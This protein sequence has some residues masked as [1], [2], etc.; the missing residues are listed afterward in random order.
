[1]LKTRLYAT[2]AAAVV[3]LATT[4]VAQTASHATSSDLRHQYRFP[5]QVWD[6]DIERARLAQPQTN[7]FQGRL[8]VEYRD[9]TRF[10]ADEMRDWTD[11]DYFAEKTLEAAAGKRIPPEPVGDWEIENAGQRRDLSQA[12]SRLLS[13]L[14]DG[15]AVKAPGDAAVAQVSYDCWIEQQEE[16]WQ[17]DHIQA[18]RQQFEAA[19]ERVDLAMRPAPQPTAA[20]PKPEPKTRV[21][22]RP[23]SDFITLYFDFD[24]ADIRPDAQREIDRFVESIDDKDETEVIVVGH[25]DRAGPPDYNLDLSKRR[26]EAVRNALI[27]EGLRI[28]KLKDFDLAA[29]GESEPA[30]PTADGVPEQANRRVVLRAYSLEKVVAKAQP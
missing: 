24:K 28:S 12:R 6:R 22:L 30:V 20:A 13:A 19:M 14:A 23:V 25:A 3:G 27:A 2:V 8:V 17:I 7:D 18:C 1:M 15:A 10:E 11:A 4:S 16:G 29:K 21:E 26:A 9:L 5:P